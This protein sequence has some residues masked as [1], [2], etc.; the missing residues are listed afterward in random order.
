MSNIKFHTKPTQVNRKNPILVVDRLPVV[1]TWM[2][3]L[4]NGYFVL[5]AVYDG[6]RSEA[7]LAA[8]D[9]NG[10]VYYLDGTKVDIHTRQDLVDYV[11]TWDKM[12]VFDIVKMQEDLLKIALVKASSENRTLVP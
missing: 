11:K 10:H 6:H 12:T 1:Q 4:N 8:F 2:Y 5:F 3:E 9:D 7:N